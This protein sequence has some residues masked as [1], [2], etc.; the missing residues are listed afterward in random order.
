MVKRMK[1][2]V[3]SPISK[4]HD[5]CLDNWVKSIREYKGVDCDML[6]IDNTLDDGVFYQSIKVEYPDVK[7]L[8]HEYDNKKHHFLEMLAHVRERIRDY[9]IEGDYTHLFFID[10]DTT[11]YPEYPKQLI[12]YDKDRVGPVVAVFYR[13]IDV[14]CVLH[15]GYV[16]M[17]FGID[18]YSWS[19]II[20]AKERLIKVHG[21]ALGCT[22][23]KRR[24]MEDCHFRSHPSFIYGED[25][26]FNTEMNDKGFE[27]WCDTDY[28]AFHDNTPWTKVTEENKSNKCIKFWVAFGPEDATEAELVKRV[29]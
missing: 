16:T 14:P 23:I 18:Y 7:I 28:K 13:P 8:R 3:A 25:L 10:V 4:R 21:N 22:M 26:W 2:L 1:I 20:L 24:V 12:D 11:V 29:K 6:L 17:G 5:Y 19:E 9:F 27:C 15:T